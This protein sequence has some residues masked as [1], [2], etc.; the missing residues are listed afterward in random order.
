MSNFLDQLSQLIGRLGSSISANRREKFEESDPVIRVRGNT[1]MAVLGG[2]ISMGYLLLIGRASALML[3]PDPRLEGKARL[4]FEQTVKVEGRRG[5]IIDRNGLILAT[6]VDL[7]ALHVDPS[8]MSPQERE[9]VTDNGNVEGTVF[10]ELDWGDDTEMEL[11]GEADEN[12]NI[13]LE[14]EGVI[15]TDWANL[16]VIGAGEVDLD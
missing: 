10:L 4:Q 5:D 2:L 9:L 16:E 8:L 13:E 3:L 6:T 14:T 1:R 7:S 15:E 11:W 12:G